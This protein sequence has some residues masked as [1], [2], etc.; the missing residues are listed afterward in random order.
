[1]KLSSIIVMGVAGSGKT[2]VGRRLADDLGFAF[3]DADDFQ[4]PDNIEKMRRGIPLDDGDRARWLDVLCEQ[5][6]DARAEREPMV[7]A[8]SALKRAYRDVLGV[9]SADTALVY[10][11]A[12]PELV[13]SRVRGRADHFMP[14]SL[15]PSQ[16]A[17]LEEPDR[18][19]VVDAALPPEAI[20]RTIRA[21]L[22]VNP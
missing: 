22:T 20:V 19:I 15:V 21:A 8:C 3:R 7:L 4:P 12:T 17:T 9:P 1:V 18:A 11:R 13:E 6:S 5:I 10:L 14:A 16:F 2:T